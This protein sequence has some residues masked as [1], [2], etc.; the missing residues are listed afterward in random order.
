MH[1]Y[2]YRHVLLP[3]FEGILKGR[4]I[5]PHWRTLEQSQWWPRAQIDQLQLCRLRR[6]L[7]HAQRQCPYYRQTWRAKGL[8]PGQV[9]TLADFTRWP[10][11][12]RA[13]VMAQRLH[14]R[15]QVPGL[16]LLCKSTG[17][18]SGSPLHFD[19]DS[20]S[21]DRR[22]A[23]WHRGYDWAGAGPGTRQLYL[24]GIPLGQRSRW[25]RWKD[26]LYYALQRRLI[27][28]T[29]EMRQDNVTEFLRMHNRYRPD[30]VVAYTNPLYTFAR[31]L[32]ERGLVPFSPRAI[33]VGAEKLYPFQRELIERVFQ[34][35]V[36]ETYGSREVML[37]G[38]E[39]DRHEGLHLTA[40]HLLVEI[41]DDQG[42]LTPAGKEGNVVVTDLYNYGMPFIRYA[43]GDRALAGWGTCSCGRGLPL[44][45]KV[46]GR[47]LDVIQT[48]DGR[49]VPGEFFPHLMKDF[50]T[51]RQFQVVQPEPDQVVVRMVLG[52]QQN[53]R[54][55]LSLEDEIRRILGPSMHCTFV[56]VDEIPLTASGKLQVVANLVEKGVKH[57]SHSAVCGSA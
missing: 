46:V 37:I 43:N 18:S 9:R 1:R 15:A 47:R 28:N 41:L 6:L 5:F 35:P 19:Y 32:E 36:F 13:T 3:A 39:C 11:I 45:R 16:R 17:G 22:F 55:R 51:V 44:L 25:Q 29:F 53:G 40:E 30:A 24:W 8:D 38:A 34:A 27:L 12:E 23:A 7:L 31:L 4:R 26:R 48:P 10:V 54:H 20:G 49:C 56:T 52:S 50:P 2:L 21:L 14:M 42:Q 57:S 33:V